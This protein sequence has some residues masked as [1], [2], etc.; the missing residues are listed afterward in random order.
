MRG[1]RWLVCSTLL[2]VSGLAAADAR[3]HGTITPSTAP[4][5]AKEQFS[6]VVPNASVNVP[7][8][9]FRLTPPAGV[10]AKALESDQGWSMT[11]EGQTLVWSDSSVPAGDRGVF[12]F[13]AQLPET[14]RTV[15]FQGE[16]SYPSVPRSGL[17]PLTV[18]MTDSPS[19]STSESRALP[20]TLILVGA[21]TL[22]A[23]GLVI[24]ASRR[25]G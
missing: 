17:F 1:R 21:L 9:G 19:S 16:E 7:L 2:L 8:T 4:R 10:E 15:T 14:G 22:A 12:E 23:L 11:V 18:A 6:I 24:A 25:R 20:I 5:G 3:A 13:E